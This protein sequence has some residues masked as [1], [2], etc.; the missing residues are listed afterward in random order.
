MDAEERREA[1]DLLHY[2][3]YAAKRGEWQE[4]E[5]AAQEARDLSDQLANAEGSAE[6]RWVLGGIKYQTGA[7]NAALPL[8]ASAQQQ[9]G[10]LNLPHQQ[11]TILYLLAHCH[12]AL[13]RPA[14]AIYALKLARDILLQTP[15]IAIANLR[16]PLCVERETLNRLIDQLLE[17]L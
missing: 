16:W 8:L 1:D 2:A 6:A 4:A 15:T 12:L 5:E 9:F 13:E 17:R 11:C 14:K 7:F 3:Y 10:L